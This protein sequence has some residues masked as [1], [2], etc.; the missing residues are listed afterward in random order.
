MP[1][2][3]EIDPEHPS[4]KCRTHTA[5]YIL[6]LKEL[7]QSVLENSVQGPYTLGCLDNIIQGFQ[8]TPSDVT[9]LAH[10]CLSSAQF[11]YFQS[12]LKTLVLEQ[13]QSN[14]D[15]GDENLKAITQEMQSGTGQYADLHVQVRAL[16]LLF[17]QCKELLHGAWISVP[18]DGTPNKSFT[19]VLQGLKE[20]Y[21]QFPARLQEAVHRQ[22][23]HN[24]AAKILF[25]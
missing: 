7:R 13:A 9:H 4:W 25:H 19:Q 3:E 5:F 15:S 18:E 12:Q 17:M 14:Q 23:S 21:A 2:T 10:T 6:L 22:I 16:P 1:V 8:M 24:N 11:L 20:T